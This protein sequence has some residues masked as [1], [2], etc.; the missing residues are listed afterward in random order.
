MCSESGELSVDKLK[1]LIPWRIGH[2]RLHQTTI[3]GGPFRSQHR[4]KVEMTARRLGRRPR[5]PGGVGRR[6]CQRCISQQGPGD[7]GGAPVSSM[8]AGLPLSSQKIVRT[9]E[10]RFVNSGISALAAM[11]VQEA[12]EFVPDT[13]V[14]LRFRAVNDVRLQRSRRSLHLSSTAAPGRARIRSSALR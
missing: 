13:R 10:M 4:R 5:C 6:V 8:A 3:A 9:A 2:R 1:F 11:F 12:R 7:A 14:I